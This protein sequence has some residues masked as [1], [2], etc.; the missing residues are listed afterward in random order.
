MDSLDRG[1]TRKLLIGLTL[2]A[3]FILITLFII[4]T[5][6][7]LLVIF[8][9]AVLAVPLAFSADLINRRLKIPRGISLL[10]VVLTVIFIG[11]GIIVPAVPAMI[12]QG[13]TLG[14]SIPV[15]LNR[16]HELSLQHSWASPFSGMFENP[17][18]MFQSQD[19][20][21]GKLLTDIGGMFSN[22]MAFMV[23]PSIILL[24]GIYLAADPDMY[25]NG[26]LRLFPHRKRDRMNQVISELGY[27]LRWWL[28]GQGISMTILGIST[29]ILLWILGVPLAVFLGILTAIM[30]FIPNIGPIIASIPTILIAL[31]VSPLTA[32]IV[33]IFYI[34][35]QNIEGAI[36]T[37]NIHARI[38]SM[39]PVLIIAAQVLLSTMVGLVGVILAMP[40]V[41]V[42][43]VLVRR[44]YIEDVLGDHDNPEDKEKTG[45]TDTESESETESKTDTESGTDEDEKKPDDDGGQEA[46]N[47]DENV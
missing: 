37:P 3:A 43:M 23:Y 10:I 36:I 6:E 47:P 7:V 18:E 35:I 13:I 14:R 12:E 27:T 1:F 11:A 16:L 9:G 25:V 33:L 22:T 19:M 32:L 8:A 2:T 45:E 24:V 34:V 26:I 21:W 5:F 20:D 29:T 42:S 44:L 15:A 39:P 4:Y 40:I 17:M 31:T 28:F 30:T 41:A 46:R 38:I